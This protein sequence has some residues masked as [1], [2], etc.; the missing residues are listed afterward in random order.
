MFGSTLKDFGDWDKHL[1]EHIQES[2]KEHQDI[3]QEI[4][5][6]RNEIAELTKLIKNQPRCPDCPIGRHPQL[7]IEKLPE[8]IIDQPERS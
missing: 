6:L 4:R 8:I 2:K 5:D 3:R 1:R 7:F